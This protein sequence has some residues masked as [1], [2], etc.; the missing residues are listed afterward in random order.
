MDGYQ[1]LDQRLV[2]PESRLRQACVVKAVVDEERQQER[3]LREVAEI[4]G[5]R[6]LRE[7]GL[8]R[9]SRLAV[10]LGRVQG[11]FTT[12]PLPEEEPGKGKPPLL[13]TRQPCE[14]R[15]GP[16]GQADAGTG[17]SLR[18]TRRK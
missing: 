3:I 2:S 5:L 1:V 13:L 4:G 11:L 16:A 14:L 7:K 10:R 12:V 18:A 6:K 9:G 15:N 8:R 17:Q